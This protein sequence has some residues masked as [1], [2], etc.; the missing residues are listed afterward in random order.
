MI[1][2]SSIQAVVA[3]LRRSQS[4]LFI[5][6]AGVSADSGLP[7]YRGIGGLY[8]SGLTEEGIPFEIAL[9]GEMLAQRPQVTWKYLMQVEQA[10]RKA[11]FNRA[12]AVIAEMER[13]F[14]RVWVLTQNV[15]GF[16][17]AAGSR[18]IIDIHGDMHG[19]A[20]TQ[21]AFTQI[22]PDYSGLQEIPPHCPKCQA[23]LRP[24]VVFFGEMLAQDKV[25]RLNLELR[26]GFD[27][28]F[29]VGTTS[30][31]PYIIEPVLNAKQRGIPTVEINP[32]TTTVSE[33]VDIRI[34]GGAA[35]TMDAI[36]Q[37]YSR[38]AEP[39]GK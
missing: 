4:L 12:H 36:W 6:G 11:A 1:D 2:P 30:V 21:C 38:G 14:P 13:Q 32:S 24:Q 3:H 15:D 39:S 10:G 17:R 33:L 31:F 23:Y 35:E 20:C 34:P 19:L 37:E 29:S 28:V 18:N 9:S 27:L 25:Q 5:T 7:T 8:N 22:V 16:H 26:R